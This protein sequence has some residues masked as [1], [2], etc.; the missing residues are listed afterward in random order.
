MSSFCERNRLFRTRSIRGRSDSKPRKSQVY[1]GMAHTRKCNRRPFLLG[2]AGYYRRF[3]HDF[4]SVAAPFHR[5]TDKN[6]E[7]AWTEA[8]QKAFKTLKM[9]LSTAP[10]LRFPVPDAP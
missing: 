6:T 9:A 7:W 3:V 2:S 8:H 1:L 5:L 10:I 4:A